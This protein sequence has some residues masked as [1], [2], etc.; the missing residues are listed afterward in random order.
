M[1][2]TSLSSGSSGNSLLVE[3]GYEKILIDCGFSGKYILQKLDEIKVDPTKITGI[4]ITHEHS[5]HIKG[6]G[7][8][9]RKL[10]V[11]IYLTR[12]TYEKSV[13]CLGKLKDENLKFIRGKQFVGLKD[14]D[15]LPIKI[16]HDAKEPVGFVI[17]HENKKISVIS[18]TGFID[19]SMIYEIKGSSLYYFESNHDVEKLING[20]YSLMLKKRILSNKGH[21]SNEQAGIYLA[22]LLEGHGEK[23]FLSHLSETNNTPK[24][25]FDTVK[26]ILR[27]YGFDCE[28]TLDIRVC[29]RYLPMGEII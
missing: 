26:G 24:L 16:H 3:S 6:A 23:V 2:F 11:P 9:S 25:A 10:D 8:L 29:P 4:F 21:L 17:Y 18:D 5:D 13:K 15:I 27:S 22:D 28:R 12:G 1:R 20:P 19:Q 7:V 14:L